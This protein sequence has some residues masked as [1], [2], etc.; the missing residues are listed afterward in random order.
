MAFVQDSLLIFLTSLFCCADTLL[1][2]L[3]GSDSMLTGDSIRNDKRAD[4]GVEVHEGS[5]C[6]GVR[7]PRRRSNWLF[8]IDPIPEV[9]EA[10]E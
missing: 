4:V 7:E 9:L 5:M 3:S 6:V 2:V 10:V 8:S 1:V